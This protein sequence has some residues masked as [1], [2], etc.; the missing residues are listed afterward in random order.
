MG[1]HKPGKVAIGAFVDVEFRDYL[2]KLV[3]E[4]NL[5]TRSDAIKQIIR[6]HMDLFLK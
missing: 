3:E 6:D 1:F 2:D 4:N 5:A